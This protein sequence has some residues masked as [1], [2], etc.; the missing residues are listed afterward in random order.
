MRYII[1]I[2]KIYEAW[3]TTLLKG[4]RSTLWTIFDQDPKYLLL[5]NACQAVVKKITYLFT[6]CVRSRTQLKE[7]FYILIGSSTYFVSKSE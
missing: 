5:A 4:M 1:L 3:T 6:L 2:S 7:Y